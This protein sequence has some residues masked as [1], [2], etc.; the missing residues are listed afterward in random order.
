[1]KS[2]AVPVPGLGGIKVGDRSL[3]DMA[4]RGEDGVPITCLVTL[5]KQAYT[6]EQ[7]DYFDSFLEAALTAIRV[8]PKDLCMYRFFI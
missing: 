2:S 3:M 8:R 7:W 4:S 1:M 5:T 6:Y